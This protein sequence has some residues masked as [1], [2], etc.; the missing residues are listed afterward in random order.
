[1]RRDD[2]IAGLF[3][4]IAEAQ[5]K[6]DAGNLIRGWVEVAK[7]AGLDK[8]DALPKVLRPEQAALRAKFEALSDAELIAIAEGGKT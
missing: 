5:K 6:A 2:V 7:F 1:M 3:T 4:G 8:P